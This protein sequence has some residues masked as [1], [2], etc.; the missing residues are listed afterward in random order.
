MIKATDFGPD[1]I[2]GFNQLLRTDPK[3]KLEILSAYTFL[4]GLFLDTTA[5]PTSAKTA[6]VLKHVHHLF[7]ALDSDKEPVATIT[8]SSTSFL[9]I[10]NIPIIPNLP[11]DEWMTTT[12]HMLSKQFDKSPVGKLLAKNIKHKL[13]IMHNS[14][15]SDSCTAWI[16][17][18]DTMSGANAAALIGKFIYFGSF[19]CRIVGAKPHPGSLQC[20]QCQKWG[21]HESKCHSQS[22]RC[23][24]CGG[25]HH[26]A[27][28]TMYVKVKQDEHH[29]VNC[30][31]SKRAKNNHASMD[32]KC[33]F[34]Q[35]RFD[36]NWLKRQFKCN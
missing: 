7:P 35:N 22:M 26:K 29:C 8:P 21:H 28:H 36:C 19:S 20:T 34:W 10:I 15:H 2:L 23:P 13:R 16:D 6:F 33:L 30:T 32:H 31:S 4:E 5:T 17:I 3:S 11:K 27:N 9:N 18:H 12:R 24:L 14:P 25:P 1:L